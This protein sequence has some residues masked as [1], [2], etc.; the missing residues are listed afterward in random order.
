MKL[1]ENRMD[2]RAMNTFKDR[3]FNSEFIIDHT[4]L[5]IQEFRK[6]KQIVLNSKLDFIEDLILAEIKVLHQ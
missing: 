4:Y 6:I 3:L 2:F 1:H 5:T